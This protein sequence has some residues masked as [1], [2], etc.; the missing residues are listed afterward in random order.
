MEGLDVNSKEQI[1][2]TRASSSEDLQLVVFDQ[3]HLGMESKSEDEM[4]VA[5]PAKEKDENSD[6][7]LSKKKVNFTRRL[8]SSTRVP[9]RPSKQIQ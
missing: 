4:E 9:S 3:D 7:E 5:H 2:G 6:S 1:G 8:R